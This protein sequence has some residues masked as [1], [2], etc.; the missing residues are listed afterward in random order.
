VPVNKVK[1]FES[2]F[3]SYLEAKHKD[4][5]DALA[6]GK[7]DDEITGVLENAAKELT[8]RYTTR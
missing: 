8:A 5:L 7:F 6:K 3:L 4:T 2:E 1:E